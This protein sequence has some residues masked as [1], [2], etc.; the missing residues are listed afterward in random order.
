MTDSSRSTLAEPFVVDLVAHNPLDAPLSL[1]NVTLEAGLVP[2]DADRAALKGLE[3]ET[4]ADI[5]LGPGETR[6]VGISLTRVL[7]PCGP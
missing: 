7:K 3:I 6:R 5:Q 2:K 4:I 1:G